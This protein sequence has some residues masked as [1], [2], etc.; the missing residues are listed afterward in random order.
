MPERRR[1]VIVMPVQLIQRRGKRVLSIRLSDTSGS[2]VFRQIVDQVK[3]AVARG[4]LATGDHLPPVRRLARELGV[5]PGTA[6]RAY[7]ELGREGIV[8]AR[9]GGGT[10]VRARSSDPGIVRLRRNRLSGMMSQSI[11][12]ALSGGYHPDELEDSFL[13]QLSRW[14]EERNGR[15]GHGRTTPPLSD[16]RIVGSHDL[17]LELLVERV[18][19]EHPELEVEMS[20]AGSLGG[21]IALQERRADVAGVHLLDE[22]TGTYNAPY[23]KHLLPGR[24]VAV[25]HLADRIQGLMFR[26]ENPKGLTGLHDLRRRD[27]RFINRQQGA[28]TRVLLDFKLRESGIDPSEVNGYEREV[29]T[30]LAV[31]RSIARNEADLGLGIEAAARSAGIGFEPLF[32]ERY[33]LVVTY[34]LYESGRFTP[35]L[36]TMAGSS[37]RETVEKIGGYDMSDTGSVDFINCADP[38]C[39]KANGEE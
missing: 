38:G 6:A 39:R 25:V 36:E 9:Q 31:A 33:D 37:F 3:L 12:E 23:V 5:S 11:L 30:H 35:F 8:Q 2:P 14:R 16:V 18:R 24:R 28:G 19:E 21:L 13:L 20:H 7:A 1:F 4:D 26:K 17:A 34:A 32:G 29:D 27:V 22:D 15:R 10:T